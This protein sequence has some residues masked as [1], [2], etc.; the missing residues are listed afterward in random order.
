MCLCHRYEDLEKQLLDAKSQAEQAEEEEELARAAAA[1][2]RLTAPDQMDSDALGPSTEDSE[3]GGIVQPSSS[4]RR[5]SGRTVVTS[6]DEA[7]GQGG[8]ASLASLSKGVLQPH[9]ARVRALEERMSEVLEV[10]NLGEET[11]EEDEGRDGRSVQQ[12]SG[13]KR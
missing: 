12:K 3:G 10:V 11:T 9:V 6:R 2:A 13:P 5:S 4:G 7:A 8:K 1:V